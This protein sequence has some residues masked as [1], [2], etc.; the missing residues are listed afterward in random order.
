MEKVLRIVVYSVITIVAL[1]IFVKL[2][3]AIIKIILLLGGFSIIIVVVLFLV[4][5]WDNLPTRK[6]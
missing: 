5:L 3:P 2:I 6:K 1:Y 4:I